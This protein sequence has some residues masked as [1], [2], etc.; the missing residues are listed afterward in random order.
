MAGRSHGYLS[1]V[2]RARRRSASGLEPDRVERSPGD[3]GRDADRPTEIP[4]RGWKD[5]AI[6][7]KRELTVDHVVLSAAGVAFWVFLSLIPA[8]AALVSLYGLFAD[9]AE[10]ERQVGEL[11]TTLPQEA[12]RLVADQLREIASAGRTSL[13]VGLAVSVVLSLWTASGAVAHLVEAVNIAYEDPPRTGLRRRGL[14]LVLTLGGLVAVAVLVALVSALGALAAD[15]GG[16]LRW[17]LQAVSWA[18]LAV[19]F[20]LAISAIYRFAPNRDRPRWRWVSVGSAVA[21]VG[22]LLASLGFRWYTANV[23][24]YNETYGSLAAIVLLLLW[25]FIAAFV[26]LLGAQINAELEHQT[27][28][29]STVGEP[30]PLG[31]R[32]ATMADRL[33]PPPA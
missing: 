16:P 24:S 4:A 31:S 21:A 6:R 9:P 25:L 18:T 7:V 30:E 11:L 27:E 22:L 29:D 33:A 15:A 19:G 20:A 5:V 2:R 23:G 1:A 32:G 28:R 14:A 8:L 13:N 10:V 26:V 12:Q 3:R 17:L